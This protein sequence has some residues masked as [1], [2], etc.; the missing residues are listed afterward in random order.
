MIKKY[1]L[2]FYNVL[3]FCVLIVVG[4]YASGAIAEGEI[5]GGFS[6]LQKDGGLSKFSEHFHI[7][8]SVWT[9]PLY[10]RL[11]LERISQRDTKTKDDKFNK[12]ATIFYEWEYKKFVLKPMIVRNLQK[13]VRKDRYIRTEIGVDWKYVW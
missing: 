5:G 11:D 1:Q 12:S 4:L 10:L 13:G 6:Q 9:I 2:Y 8:Q 7:E 3:L